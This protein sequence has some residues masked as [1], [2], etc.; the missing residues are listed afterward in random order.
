M[1]IIQFGEYDALIDANGRI[2]VPRKISLLFTK[3]FLMRAFNG[4][5]LVFLSD[6]AFK[7]LKKRLDTLGGSLGEE[8]RR[9][10]ACGTDVMLDNHGR[11]AVNSRLRTWARLKK[12]VIMVV[13]DDKV[14]IWDAGEW[15]AYN[16]DRYTRER[17]QFMENA[18]F[19]STTDVAAVNEA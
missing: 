7:A 16:R 10:V 17:L 12:D 18:L 4:Q 19:P 11:L 5:S 6:D 9:F 3:G 8:A 15:D 2:N 14:E 13:M 1:E